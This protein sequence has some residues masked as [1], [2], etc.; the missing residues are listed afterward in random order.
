MTSWVAENWQAVAACGLLLTLWATT[1]LLLGE[2]E[3][4]GRYREQ[5]LEHGIAPRDE[6]DE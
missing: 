2:R 6:D 3:R 4:A 1:C 5:L